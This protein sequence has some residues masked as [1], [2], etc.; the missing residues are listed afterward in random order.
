MSHMHMPADP[1][2][3]QK[4]TFGAGCF[5]GV[6][7]A[8]RGVPGVLDTAVGY[9]GGTL[10]HPTYRDVCSGTT[11]HAEVVE[12]VFDPANVSYENLLDIFFGIHDPTTPDRQGVDIGTQ[13]RSVIF[14]HSPEQRAAA[15]A[16]KERVNRSGR[17]RR[18]VVTEIVLAQE[19]WRVEEYHQR[20]H[21]KH[22]RSG[23][24]I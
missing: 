2:Q 6:E 11:G 18:P 24:G 16:A 12:V 10:K 1:P 19:F 21:E 22:G 14:C 4:A 7:A 3:I 23:C 15:D 17:F 13:Y 9:M 8:F 20:S 5:W